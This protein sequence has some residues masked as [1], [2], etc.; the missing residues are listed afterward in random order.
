MY[1]PGVGRRVPANPLKRRSATTGQQGMVTIELAFS[2]F[3]LT[4]MGL[5]LAWVFAV[6]LSWAQCEDLAVAVA[7]Q[8]ARGDHVAVSTIVQR[9]PAGSE[10]SVVQR[11]DQI[12]VDVHFA[13]RPWASWLPSVPLTASASITAEPS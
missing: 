7:R 13:A 4:M 9:R 1:K 11:N 12:T 6:V 10:V 2:W 8:Q 5:V 3:A